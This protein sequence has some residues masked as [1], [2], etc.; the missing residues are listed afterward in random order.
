MTRPVCKKLLCAVGGMLMN[1]DVVQPYRI[2]GGE[3]AGYYC[4]HDVSDAALQSRRMG[5]ASGRFSKSTLLRKEDVRDVDMYKYIIAS[6]L[7][8]ELSQLDNPLCE[9]QLHQL[10]RILCHFSHCTLSIVRPFCCWHCHLFFVHSFIYLFVRLS[11]S[12]AVYGILRAR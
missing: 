4:G 1:F 7:G 6:C 12:G 9:W 8:P 5:I 2:L 10:F 11:R 3:A